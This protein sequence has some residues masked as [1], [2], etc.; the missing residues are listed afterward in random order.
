MKQLVFRQLVTL[1]PHRVFDGIV[2]KYHGNKNVR[3]FTCW[4]LLLVLIY[5]QL[6][7]LRSLREFISISSAH[8]KKCKE[9]GFG[10]VPITRSNL[11]K[12]LAN[13][14]YR[15]FEEFAYKMVARAQE[16]RIKRPFVL[17][18]K[19]YAFDSTTIELCLNM[20]QWAHFREKK[21][22]I[23][24]HTMLDIVTQIPTFFHITDAKVNDV[25]A[26]DE[27]PY[28]E[29]ACYI[30][31]RGY[32][33]WAR[34]FTINLLGALFVTR[35]RKNIKYEI[36]DGEH[37]KEKQKTCCPNKSCQFLPAE[38]LR[39]EW[40]A[41]EKQAI[42][43]DAETEVGKEHRVVVVIRAV[44]LAY[45]RIAESAINNAAKNGVKNQADSYQSIF[46]RR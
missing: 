29:R 31:D 15:I 13:R 21:G 8:R 4:N 40:R 3:S 33:D 37:I 12:A 17:C 5:S 30:F 10:D 19:Y 16:M 35:Q 27:I 44:L 45:E 11:A 39:Y 36:I 24:V 41:D 28:E 20:F 42:E 14:D 43:H 25:N 9:L 38:E 34:Y 26:M 6:S 32:Y 2:D 23:K 46:V 7:G 18:G 1:L 22:G